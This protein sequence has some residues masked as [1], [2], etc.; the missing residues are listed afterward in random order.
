MLL[1]FLVLVL[2]Y[3]YGEIFSVSRMQ[4]LK[5]RFSDLSLPFHLLKTEQLTPLSVSPPFAV[6][7]TL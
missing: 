7:Y 6:Q 4:A 1:I 5:K 2:L 3:A